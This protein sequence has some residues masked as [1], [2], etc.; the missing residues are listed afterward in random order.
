MICEKSKCTGCMACYNVCPV[1]AIVQEKDEEGFTRPKIIEEKCIKCNKCVQR[2]P[3]NQGNSKEQTGT[4][5]YACWNKQEQIRKESTS[6]GLFSVMAEKILDLNGVVYGAVFDKDM[7]VIHDRI[8][9]KE[10]IKRLRGSKYVQSDIGTSIKQVL[11]DLKEEKY[12]LFSRY[13]LSN[14]RTK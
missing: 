7:K 13:A 14:S 12:V 6:G 1:N 11:Q 9:N 5:T 10:A 3:I 8:D 4:K 2:C